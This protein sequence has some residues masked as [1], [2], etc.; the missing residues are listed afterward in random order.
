MTLLRCALLFTTLVGLGSTSAFAQVHYHPNGAPWSQRASDGPDAEVPGWYYN[1]GVTGIRVE[2]VADAPKH[3]VVRHVFGDSPAAKQVRVG[4]VI[5][6]A[7]GAPFATDH[8][9]G[10]GMDVFGPDGPILEF[11]V[12][13]EACRTKSGKGR[14]SLQLLRDDEPLEVTLKL[15]TKSG[16][17]S[18]TF[19]DQCKKS[20]QVLDT[21]LEH[22]VDAQQDDGSWGI[23]PQNLFAPLALLAS[24]ERK[25]RK[26]VEK[27]VRFH[28]RT[29]REHDE[30]GLINWRYM[31]AAIVMSEYYLATREAWVLDELQE[32]YDFLVWSQYV[33]MDTQL[34]PKAKE[35]H[36]GSYPKSAE[37]AYGGWGHNPGFEGYGPICMLTGQGALAF[38]LMHRCGIEVDRHRHEAAYAFLER[39]S[40]RNGYVWYEDSAAGQD[41]WADMGR[42]G[43]SGVAHRLSPYESQAHARRAMIHAKV[44]GEHPESF[45]DTHGSPVLGM[46]FAALG[47]YT[48]PVSFRALMD[49]NRWWFVLAECTDGTFY[50]Q[51]NRDNAGYGGNSRLSASAVTAFILSIPKGNL[52]LTA[53]NQ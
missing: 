36:P 41:D 50:Y 11:A 33:D 9:N 32:V 16:T 47:A 23:P 28:A 38:A 53:K 19:P 49:A 29:T 31:A 8:K 26:A 48:D 10:Y 15:E 4:D 42:T 20:D 43:V 35:S 5:V 52:A 14:L 24:G 17:Y 1:L 34:N 3:L 13:L 37:E 51:P 40:G 30:D 25:H 6:G 44:I 45:P 7:G 22:L 2:L 27:N 18:A 46:G 39:G 12:A 21:L